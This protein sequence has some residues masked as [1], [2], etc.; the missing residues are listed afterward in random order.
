MRPPIASI[1]RFMLRLVSRIQ[2]ISPHFCG[3][4]VRG[5]EVL[6]VERRRDPRVLVLGLDAEE[7]DADA[8]D[9]PALAQE[10]PPAERQQPP[11]HLHQHLVDVG[12][13]IAIAAVSPSAVSA[14][15]NQLRSKTSCISW[16]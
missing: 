12:T 16:A 7:A 15:M 1:A 9:D 3:T 2:P 10:V 11:L 5:V 6:D 4:R 14:T 8:V 13:V